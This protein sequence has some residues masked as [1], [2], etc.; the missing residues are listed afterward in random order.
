MTGVADY[1]DYLVKRPE[2]AAV[3]MVLE[4]VRDGERF[5]AAVE[6]AGA[7]GVPPG[8]AQARPFGTIARVRLLPQRRPCGRREG[9]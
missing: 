3:A 2:T 1:L 5:L 7:A 8:R 4:T 6:A 9:P